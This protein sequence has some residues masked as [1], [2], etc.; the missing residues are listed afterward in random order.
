[1]KRIKVI[2][3]GIGHDHTTAVLDS[4]LRQN[5]VFGVAAL[6]VPET[7]KTDFAERLENYRTKVSVMSV[8]ESFEI[9]GVDA[10]VIETEEENLTAYAYSAAEIGLAVI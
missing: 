7:E 3:I 2:Q 4:L 8:R 6:A 1:M 9:C 5:N 10:A